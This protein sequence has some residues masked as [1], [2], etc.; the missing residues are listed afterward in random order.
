MSY[1]DVPGH[2]FGLASAVLNFNRYPELAVAAARRLLWTVAEHY[3]DDVDSAEPSWAGESGQQ[4]L[5][6]LCN[7]EFFGFGFDEEQ[8]EKM[9]GINDYLGVS[10][11]L[12][13]TDDG[14]ML[15]TVSKKRRDKIKLLVQESI[16][17]DELRSGMA[18]S[19]FGKARFMISPCYGGLGNACLPPVNLRSRQK[20]AIGLSS[21]LRESLEFIEFACDNLPPMSL[22]VL[23]NSDNK[24][25]I[26]VDAE[27][28]QRPGG[29]PPLRAP[30]LCHI[31][32]RIWQGALLCPSA[33][34]TG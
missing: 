22:S 29:S 10:S 34:V 11:D 18:A 13:G 26:F 31:P 9:A 12:R 14:F 6:T 1:C 27:G 17:N 28:K 33:D 24:V 15:M 7:G 21:D 19:I 23:P 25:V 2:N 5:R 20:K 32:S 3:Y 8:T 4:A 16:L 30:W